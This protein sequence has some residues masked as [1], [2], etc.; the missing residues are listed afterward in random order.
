[1]HASLPGILSDKLASV[2]GCGVSTSLVE[3]LMQIPRMQKRMDELISTRLGDVGEL[4]SGQARVLAMSPGHLAALSV[5]AGA[6]WHG[7]AIVRLIDRASR[8][9]L[10]ELLGEKNYGLALACLDLQP[11]GITLDLAPEDIAKAV[12]VDGAACLAVWC[13]FQPRAVL[14]RLQLIRPAAK[15]EARHAIWGPQIVDRLLADE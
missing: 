12:P 14:R 13:D 6:V 9:S 2:L 11:D 8:Q 10:L 4:T 1:M 7:G 5:R 15:P 3:R